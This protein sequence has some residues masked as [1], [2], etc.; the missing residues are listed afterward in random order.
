MPRLTNNTRRARFRTAAAASLAV[1]LTALATPKA[2]A[3]II[4]GEG[5]KPIEDPGWPKGAAAIF[6]TPSR[7]AWWEGPPF[8]GGQWHS[9]C[10]GDARTLSEI[11]AGFAQIMFRNIPP[12]R[13]VIQGRPNLSRGNQQSEPLAIEFIC[14]QAS[15]ITLPR[16][17]RA[18][19]GP[20]TA[21]LPASPRSS[22]R[23]ERLVLR[24]RTR[25]PLPV[26]QMSVWEYA[27]SRLHR[28]RRRSAIFTIS[29]CFTET[30]RVP[31][32]CRS[33]AGTSNASST[34][35]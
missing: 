35:A 23:P 18:F 6:N 20:L 19:L 28:S 17:C 25:P 34:D 30:Q 9:E 21:S 1:A 31:S 8:G 24:G 2:F 13:Y 4:G 33:A 26:K 16:R 27:R 11:L 3:S 22:R 12:G 10:R 14:G 15:R 7:I 32:A 29:S 5:N